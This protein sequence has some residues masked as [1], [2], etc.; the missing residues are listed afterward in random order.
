MIRVDTT[1]IL[2]VLKKRERVYFIHDHDDTWSFISASTSTTMGGKAPTVICVPRPGTCPEGYIASGDPQ[3]VSDSRCPEPTKGRKQDVSMCYRPG[4]AVFRNN[5][6][7][8][9]EVALIDH[10]FMGPGVL[11]QFRVGPGNDSEPIPIEYDSSRPVGV[12]IDGREYFFAIDY[13]GEWLVTIGQDGV[14]TARAR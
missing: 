12:R 2:L 10:G 3:V 11:R 4:R 8:E 6:P 9:A 5:R 13:G 1:P 7:S 14:P